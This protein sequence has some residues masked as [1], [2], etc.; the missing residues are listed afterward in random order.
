MKHNSAQPGDVKFKDISGPKGKPDGQITAAYDRTILGFSK[1]NFRLSFSNT[2]NYKAFTFYVLVG[3]RFGGGKHNYYVSTNRLAY[4]S[5]RVPAQN[6][7]DH[8]YWTPENENNTYPRPTY[9][10]VRFLGLQSR[11]FVKIQDV[12]LSYN[13]ASLPWIEGTGI[14]SLELYVS[15]QNLYTFTNWVGGDPAAGIRAM[16][17]AYPVPTTYMGGIKITF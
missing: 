12:T 7:L 10:N 8:P 17:G 15:G 6:Q 4:E 9:H 13:F 16:S 14:K 3:G 1:P 2:I 11:T 5:L